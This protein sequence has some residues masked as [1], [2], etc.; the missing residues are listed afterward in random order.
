MVKGLKGKTSKEW[1]R[2]FNLL[3]LEKRRLRDDL[4]AICVFFKGMSRGQALISSLWQPATEHKQMESNCIKE[5]SHQPLG[6]ASSL[7]GNMSPS[8][9]VM[10]SRVTSHV[11]VRGASGQ[12][13]VMCFNF[14]YSSYLS[15]AFDSI[16]AKEHVIAYSFMQPCM[17]WISMLTKCYL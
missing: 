1:L 14:R 13:S 9:A 4:T 15:S 5:S 11:R 12:C 17:I 2:S 6:E 3:S 7:R 10:L 16:R 8:E